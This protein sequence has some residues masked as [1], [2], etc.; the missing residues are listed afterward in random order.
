MNAEFP[1]HSRPSQP[2]SESRICLN[3]IVKDEAPVIARVLESVCH[4]IGYFVIVDTGS[5]DDT[6]QRIID[7]MQTHG[8]PGE[9]H[10]REWV[11]FGHNR[12]QA[13]ELAL[14]VK[15]CDWALFIDAD[16]ELAA[17]DPDWWR[18]LDPGVSY[19]MFKHS[20]DCRYRLPNLVWLRGPAWRWHGVVHEY[21]AAES[22]VDLQPLDSAW[23]V[24]HVGEG[25]RSRGVS[26][27]QKFLRDAALLERSLAD[28]PDNERDRFYL[29]QSYRDAGHYQKAY[30]N[31]ARRMEMGGWAEE[32]YTAACEKAAMAV[33]LGH[34][35]DAVL[36]AH[37]AAYALR[38]SRAEALWQ[39]A[40]YCREHERFAEG[41]LF[42]K[43][44]KEIPRPD[45]ILF[46]RSDVY[47]W[48]LLDE[49]AVCAYWIGQYAES[50]A[51]GR[52]LLAEG[53]FPPHERER[54]E[55]NLEFAVQQLG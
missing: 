53:R 15:R 39:L 52:R 9:V 3:M 33:R 48:R 4:A 12:Q 1:L 50:A 31:Y 16:D 25:A 23:I 17:A 8:I 28:N 43:V 41:Y 20:G 51:A 7:L 18:Q 49:F 24:M 42:A 36:S 47:E 26:Q 27:E 45:D 14:A 40:A 13:L 32:V 11:N 5:R 10:R 21:L 19:Q 38:P 29:A 37:L 22:Q 54:L 46:V 30:D 2:C 35:H 55:K 44:G 6:P 34:G